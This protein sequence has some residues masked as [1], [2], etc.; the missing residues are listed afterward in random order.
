MSLVGRWF[1]SLGA[2][3]EKDLHVSPQVRFEVGSFKSDMLLE[4]KLRDGL[5]HV[6]QDD[7]EGGKRRILLSTVSKAALKSNK[8]KAVIFP[9]SMADKSS[10]CCKKEPVI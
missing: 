3:T 2:A 1:Q 6:F 10:C 9:S 7:I 8:T 4:H 5:C